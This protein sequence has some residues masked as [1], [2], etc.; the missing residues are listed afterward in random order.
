V[1]QP[2]AQSKLVEEARTSLE[3]FG[4]CFSGLYSRVQHEVLHSRLYSLQFL[5]PQIN[6][7]LTKAFADY[8]E[9]KELRVVMTEML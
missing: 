4:E 2:R 6:H 9:I 7:Y 1:G 5:Q 8:K 3:N